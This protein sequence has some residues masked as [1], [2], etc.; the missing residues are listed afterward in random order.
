MCTH[1]GDDPTCPHRTPF[2][3][4][5]PFPP[6][7]AQQPDEPR[8]H[9]GARLFCAVLADPGAV[10]TMTDDQ[11]DL[12]SYAS[13]LA[14]DAR[15]MSPQYYDA[16]AQAGRLIAGAA[17]RR[18]ALRDVPAGPCTTIQ[19]APIGPPT[20]PAVTLQPYPSTQPPAGSYANAPT[21]GRPLTRAGDNIRF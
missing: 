21:P 10:L 5:R 1:C 18:A 17:R 13:R 12:A 20:G 9:F 11:I 14:T 2:E 15:D 8:V 16:T 7:L 6:T 4:Y 19:P 3:T